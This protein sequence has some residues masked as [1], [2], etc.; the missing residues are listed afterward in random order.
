MMLR[1]VL[2]GI[3]AGLGVTIPSQPVGHGWL[4]SAERWA[5]SL[6]AEWDTWRPDDDEGQRIPAT[7]H[8]CEQCRLARAAIAS[9]ERKA[10]ASRSAQLTR[11]AAAQPA[12]VAEKPAVGPQPAS[13]SQLKLAPVIAFDPIDI[14]DEFYV[15]VAFELNKNSEGLELAQTPANPV[16]ARAESHPAIVTEIMEVDLPDVLCGSTD[17]DVAAL[18]SDADRA[19]PPQDTQPKPREEVVS[20]ETFGSVELDQT[21]GSTLSARLAPPVVTA[22]QNAPMQVQPWECLE[23]IA[24]K[25]DCFEAEDDLATGEDTSV[26]VIAER[27][28]SRPVSPPSSP[29]PDVQAAPSQVLTQEPSKVKNPSDAL[30]WPAFAPAESPSSPQPTSVVDDTTVP[31]PVFAPIE[32]ASSQE[33]VNRTGRRDAVGSNPLST[34]PPAQTMRGP[35][36]GSG[37]GEAVHLTRQAMS[38]WLEV[39]VRT[40][41]VEVTAR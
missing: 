19:D 34:R 1:L 23:L 20:T 8:E 33:T 5:N 7:V 15:G 18:W 6:L 32:K 35:V 29:V 40:S 12:V 21:D 22:T 14:S 13:S 10:A 9:H 11:S 39:L 37:W 2:V 36:T 17:E 28:A 4:G 26:A 30:P 38:A 31:W 24:C 27:E 25:K 3:V 41:P 16:T